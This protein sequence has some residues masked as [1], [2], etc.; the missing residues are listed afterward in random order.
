M[1]EKQWVTIMFCCKYLY[2]YCYC[3]EVYIYLCN[4]MKDIWM[5]LERFFN[6]LCE[7]CSRLIL[8]FKLF[9]FSPN[10]VIDLGVFD[11]NRVYQIID[12]GKG[13][14]PQLI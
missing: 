4:I 9:F 8:I 1:C 5:N 11:V 2:V 7:I 3:I 14:S 12:L 10:L 6:D 13:L